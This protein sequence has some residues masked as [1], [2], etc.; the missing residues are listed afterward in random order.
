M[1]RLVLDACVV[2]KLFYP[3]DLSDRAERAVRGRRT[4]H[5]PDLLY[6]EL[7]NVAWK[8]VRRG[9]IDAG[10][11]MESIS[12]AMALPIETHPAGQY[13]ERA[14]ALAIETD[15]SVYDCLYLA[16]ALAERATLLTAD[17]RFAQALGAGPLGERVVWLGEAPA[18]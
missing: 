17:R 14:L 5:A 18:G 6:A 16:V 1:R 8:R 11:A 2:A 3:E 15:R 4:L 12:L 7:A 9:E 10:T 13:A